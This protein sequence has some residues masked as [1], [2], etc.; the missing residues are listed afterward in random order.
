MILAV[1]IFIALVLTFGARATV[2]GGGNVLGVLLMIVGG[3]F[4]AAYLTS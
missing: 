3:I 2:R 1:L 4:L